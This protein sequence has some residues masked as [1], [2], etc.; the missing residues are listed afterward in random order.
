MLGLLLTLVVMGF[1]LLVLPL[2][3][4]KLL[5]SL[6][7][8]LVFLPFKLLGMAFRLVGGLLG[9]VLK[10]LFS[11]I[12]LVAGLVG[13]VFF[14]VLMPLLPLLVLGFVIWGMTRLFRGPATLA[15]A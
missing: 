5:F 9:V 10:V 1:V 14:V 11:G 8:G 3:A 12:G 13:L 4:L 2:L 7:L 15:R 6:A